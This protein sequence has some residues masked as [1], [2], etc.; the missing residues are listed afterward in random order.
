M[1]VSSMY[2]NISRVE[3]KLRNF[4]KNAVIGHWIHPISF[5]QP[6]NLGQ[7]DSECNQNKKNVDLRSFLSPQYRLVCSSY[8]ENPDEGK[9]PSSLLVLI[10][11]ALI[12]VCMVMVLIMA[13]LILVGMVMVL[14]LVGMH[15]DCVDIAT[16]QRQ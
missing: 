4:C 16:F 6:L 14:I 5:A 12:L 15:G 13:A 3:T 11:A 9:K 8:S 1:P 2:L 7:F 10:M